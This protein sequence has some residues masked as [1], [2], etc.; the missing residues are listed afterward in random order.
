MWIYIFNK[1]DSQNM[2]LSGSSFRSPV[3]FTTYS[4]RVPKRKH[5]TQGDFEDCVKQSKTCTHK[6]KPLK[7]TVRKE[8][9]AK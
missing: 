7:E 9:N 2:W 4:S 1:H 3:S 8:G 5:N 6:R